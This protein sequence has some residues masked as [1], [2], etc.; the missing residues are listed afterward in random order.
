MWVG[1]SQLRLEKKN[2]PLHEETKE[3]AERIAEHCDYDIIDE[4]KESRVVL[5]MKKEDLKDRFLKL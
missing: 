2:M 3:F 1:F 4:K 5:L